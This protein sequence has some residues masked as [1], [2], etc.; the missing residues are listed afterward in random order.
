VQKLVLVFRGI[1]DIPAFDQ[2]WSQRFV[3]TAENMPGLRR[4]MVSRVQGSVSG[5]TAIHLL[6]EL[7]FDDQRA[8]EAAMG[9]PEGQAAGKLLLEIAGDHVELLFAEHLED[10]PRAS[11]ASQP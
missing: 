9:S 6:H 7:H 10:I 1:D 11:S 5:D 4:I 8:L 3:P 2:A